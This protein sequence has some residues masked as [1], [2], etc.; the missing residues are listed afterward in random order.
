LAE[1]KAI[2]V[3]SLDTVSPDS[4]QKMHVTPTRNE[5]SGKRKRRLGTSIEDALIE[6]LSSHVTKKLQE[7]ANAHES[8]QDDKLFL[9]SLNS[10][11]KKMQMNT[12]WTPSLR[13]KE[14]MASRS[15]NVSG[16]AVCYYSVLCCPK[17]KRK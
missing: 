7:S 12:N 6:T 16:I 4:T 10:D 1:E 13:F 14:I 9:M 15:T 3:R 17:L 5:L 11:L 2:T 8:I